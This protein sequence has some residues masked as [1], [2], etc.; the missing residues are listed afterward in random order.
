MSQAIINAQPTIAQEYFDI[1]SRSFHVFDFKGEKILFD[2]STGT[3]SELNEFAFE[4]L[5][6][7]REGQSV[8]EALQSMSSRENEL[9]IECLRE[10]LQ[11]LKSRG[12]FRFT[13]SKTATE[14]DLEYLWDHSPRRIQLLMAEGCNLGCR[15]CYQWRNGTNQKH[16]LMPWSIAK[17][18]IDHLIWRSGERNELQ[19]T[20]FGGEP[21]LN[22][23]MIQRVVEYCKTIEKYTTKK[24][25]F[26]LITNGTLLSRDV[27]DFLVEHQF[28]LFISLDG[29]R[30]MHEYNRPS[31]DGG[32]S[33]DT[34]VE[35]A[36]YANE[37][38]T[39][40]KLPLIKIRANLTNKYHDTNKVAK[41]FESLGFKLIGVG[42]IEPLPHGDPSPAALTED[43]MDKLTEQSADEIVTYIDK[44]KNQ[45]SLTPFEMK[46]VRSSLSP[47]AKSTSPGITCGVCRNTTVVD[48]RG[49]MYPCHRYGEMQEYVIGNISTGLNRNLV[50]DYYKKINQHATTDCQNCWIRDFCSGGCAWLLSDKEG[51]IHHPTKRECA[52]R[53]RHMEVKIWSR[54]EL[55]KNFPN[56]F[57]GEEKSRLNDWNWDLKVPEGMEQECQSGSAENQTQLPILNKLEFPAQSSAGSCASCSDPATEGCGCSSNPAGSQLVQLVPLSQVEQK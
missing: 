35:N 20:F 1:D 48:N 51:K 21:L 38:Y 31:M 55:L 9:D 47:L 37:Q 49:N 54:K 43:Q 44:L 11:D 23:P 26:E 14:A 30:E 53:R 34:I 19:V 2:R 22:Y 17:T 5:Q 15:Y 50:M 24:F 41:L 45:E 39:K 18:S 10:A 25:K 8:E 32:T 42:A 27:V 7:I 6:L 29:W 13:M 40:H 3:T 16:T 33:Y 56:W 46:S 4:T 52:R 12:F 28:L 36:L 57:E